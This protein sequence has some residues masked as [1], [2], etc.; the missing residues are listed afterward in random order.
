M[1]GAGAHLTFSTG[2]NNITRAILIGAEKRTSP[3]PT[4]GLSQLTRIERRI[5]S[6]WVT[7]HVPCRGEV[8]VVIG[9]I[10]VTHPLPDISCHIEEAV[11]IGWILRDSR[12]SRVPV[13]STVGY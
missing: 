4:L 3:H 6:V 1:I 7:R 13:L 10:P 9:P 11:T 12:D 2:T 8:L 5:R